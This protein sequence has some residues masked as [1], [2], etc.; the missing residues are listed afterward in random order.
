MFAVAFSPDG[1]FLATGDQTGQVNV[2]DVQRQQVVTQFKGDTTTVYTVKFSPD[3][4]ILAGA[5]YAG[6]IELWKVENWERLGTLSVGATVSTIDFS[7]DSTTLASTG[8]ETVNLWTVDTGETLT[9]LTGHPGWVNAVA[10]SPDGQTLI[11]GGDD[12]MLRLWDVTSYTSATQEIVRIIYFLPRDR[13][14]Q[15]DM[16]TK[17]DRLI[18][19]VQNF[20]ADEM[21]RNGFGRKAFTFE[22]DEN[23]ETIVYRVDGQSNDWYYHTQTQEKVY[24]E[25]ASQFD[26]TKHVYL[27]VVDISSESIEHEDICGGRWR[28]LV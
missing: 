15:P 25:V 10:F 22:T 2:W 7:P 26:M 12:G 23:A 13:S 11:S 18:R 14:M 27:I 1:R 6:D 17:L 28:E 5:G 16:W 8:Y 4:K 24:V 9:S 20:Y 3:G 19:N 21:E